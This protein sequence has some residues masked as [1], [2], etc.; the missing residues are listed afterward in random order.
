MTLS[1][2]GKKLLKELNEKLLKSQFVERLHNLRKEKNYEEE[3]SKRFKGFFRYL[4]LYYESIQNLVEGRREVL[5]DE[6]FR[7]EDGKSVEE[8]AE[9]FEKRINSFVGRQI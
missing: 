7:F 5:H 9:I 6:E 8:K 4:A 2:R 3:A 1:S